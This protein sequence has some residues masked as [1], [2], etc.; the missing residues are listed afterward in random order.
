MCVCV[1]VSSLDPI[2]WILL[3]LTFKLI[4]LQKK[5]VQ[6][7]IN[8]SSSGSF[9]FFLK[10][11]RLVRKTTHTSI[12]WQPKLLFLQFFVFVQLTPLNN[13]LINQSC[14]IIFKKANVI[15]IN[16]NYYFSHLEF[17]IYW[18]ETI[19]KDNFD[20]ETNILNYLSMSLLHICI[21]WVLCFQVRTKGCNEILQF[22]PKEVLVLVQ[23]K[24]LMFR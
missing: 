24:F 5:R 2:N 4:Q 6:V 17:I 1:C 7:L 22:F 16:I 21:Y 19:H 9:F 15:F 10:T 14:S 11:K 12:S 23:T 3:L 8:F 13:L 18:K 20:L